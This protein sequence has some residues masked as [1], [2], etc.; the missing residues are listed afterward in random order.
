[1]KLTSQQKQQL[2]STRP[3]VAQNKYYKK[4]PGEWYQKYGVKEGFSFGGTPQASA[5]Q[6]SV[7]PKWE[8]YHTPT[9]VDTSEMDALR[10]R[11]TEQM[12]PRPEETE[13]GTQLSNIITSRELGV[14]GV[15]QE[16]MAQKFVTGQSAALEKSAALKSLP[17]QTKLSNLIASRQ[18]AADILKTQL[19]YETADI[20]RQTTERQMGREMDWGRYQSALGQHHT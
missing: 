18:A 16:P 9:P 11:Y 7:A 8:S 13:L 17:L 5:A 6:P 15:E 19:G 10:K 12:S 20:E 1:M 4:H 2:F 14:A 3:D